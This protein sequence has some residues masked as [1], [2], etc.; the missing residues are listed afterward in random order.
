MWLVAADKNLGN[1]PFRLAAGSYVVGRGKAAQ[2]VI[3]GLIASSC[4]RGLDGVIAM[5]ARRNAACP[6]LRAALVNA[7][8]ME[9]SG[10]RS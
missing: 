5:L 9:L 4:R 2:V 7:P 10:F 6:L 3:P 8:F 1:L